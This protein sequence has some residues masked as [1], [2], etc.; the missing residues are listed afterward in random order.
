MQNSLRQN[1]RKKIQKTLN[2][3]TNSILENTKH[4]THNIEKKLIDSF[5]KRKAE[6]P[7]HI[8]QINRNAKLRKKVTII[9]VPA[10]AAGMQFLT[11]ENESITIMLDDGL[12]EQKSKFLSQ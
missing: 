12:A 3:L 9:D 7:E 10:P 8:R 6:N 11:L 1:E 4:I 2:K 5:K